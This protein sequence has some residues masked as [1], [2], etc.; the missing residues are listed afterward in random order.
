MPSHDSHDHS[1]PIARD[2][3]SQVAAFLARSVAGA[4]PSR[5]GLD[6]RFKGG[7]HRVPG[8]LGGDHTHALVALEWSL[9]DGG[10]RRMGIPRA[11]DVGAKMSATTIASMLI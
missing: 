2:A 8:Q 6:G 4:R 11:D 5:A 10:N 7:Q 3:C 9:P 1:P